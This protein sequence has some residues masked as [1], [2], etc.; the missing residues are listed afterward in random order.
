[1]ILKVQQT[2]ANLKNKFEIS[3]NNQLKY[4][5]GTPWMDLQVPFHADRMRKCVMTRIDESICYMTSYDL[6]ENIANTAIPIKWAVTGEQKSL[7]FD[8]LDANGQNCA[9]FYKLTQGLWDSKY[10]IAYAAR[11]F[12]CY[13][14]SVGRTRN[15]VIY[16]Q[17]TQIAE[18]VKPLTVSDNLDVYTIFL[19]DSCCDLES[20]FA[21][22]TV[23]FDHLH[24]GNRGEV[25]AKKKE[26]QF[27]YSYD[28]NNKFYDKNW[29]PNHFGTQE[30]EQMQ[31]QMAAL[32]NGMNI[33]AKHIVLFIILVWFVV[34]VA[35][36][37][38][39]AAIYFAK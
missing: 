36:G 17:D 25:V 23:V 26:V 5:A 7:I 22:F 19:L 12:T 16:E 30:L 31:Q 20:I 39:F 4:F 28:K 8:I 38:I 6:M 33:Q 32:Q 11:N 2:Q 15:I 18:I 27:Q 9:M 21:F 24:Y 13:D 14:I 37:S 34:L 35:V 10:V 1:M 29:I 3:V